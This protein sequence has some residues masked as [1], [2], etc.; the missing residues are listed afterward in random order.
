MGYGHG[1]YHNEGNL[2]DYDE[3]LRVNTIPDSA[4]HNQGQKAHAGWYYCSFVINSASIDQLPLPIFIRGDDVEY[5]RRNFGKTFIQLNGICIWHAPFYYRVNKITDSYYLCRNMFIVN[6]AI[7]TKFQEYICSYV[8]R[9]VS[10]CNC[11]I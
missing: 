7:H 2:L 4:F 10:I 1:P 5:S 9:K 11:H 6:T 3:V 8:S